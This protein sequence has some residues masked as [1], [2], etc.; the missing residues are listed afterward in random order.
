ME[1]PPK[2]FKDFLFGG[3]GFLLLMFNVND[4]YSYLLQ[5]N[6]SLEIEDYVTNCM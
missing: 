6:N 2:I 4:N 3:K 5:T 1:A